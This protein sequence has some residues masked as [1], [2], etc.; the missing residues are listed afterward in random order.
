[1]LFVL[2]S[3][4][5]AQHPAKVPRLGYL[6]SNSSSAAEPN[7]DA[8]RQGL[9]DLGYI[10][11]KNITI[12]YRYGDGELHR[13][14]ALANELVQLKVNIIVASST[15]AVFACQKA[16]KDI[17]ILFH[18]INDP[19]ESGLVASLARPGGN[20]TG[21]TMSGAH[22]YGKRLELLKEAIPK[23]SRVGFL[24]NP[25]TTGGPVNMKEI[26]AAAPALKT[27]IQSI[28]VQNREDLEPAFDAAT[29][30]KIGAM[31]TTQIPPITTYQ[32]LVIDLATKHHMPMMY[33]ERRWAD[34]GGL[35]S[36]GANVDDN[37]RRLAGY[38]DR[39]LKGAK[40]ADLPVERSAKFELVINLKT[41]K[42]I[43]LTIPPNVLARADRVIR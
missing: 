17:P 22:L 41:A 43:G 34:G 4:A 1:M 29:R 3:F 31:M 14:T 15:L 12:E 38:V 16:T 13:L 36:Y 19:V 39:V 28:E 9:R 37:Y 32:K 18:A 35:M 10:E 33:P 5:Q 23:L 8:F 25:T 20:T 42:Q 11:Q 27:Q 26:Q 30:A 2:C 24:W 7:V 6:S 21:L 40:P